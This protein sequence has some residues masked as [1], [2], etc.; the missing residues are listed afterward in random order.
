LEFY[1]GNIS[2]QL[3]NLRRSLEWFMPELTLGLTLPLLLVLG[4]LLPRHTHRVILPGVLGL[5]LVWVAWQ[6]FDQSGYIN[7]TLQHAWFLNLITVDH[8]SVNF[9]LL[10][11]LATA[12]SLIIALVSPPRSGWKTEFWLF[13]G[14]ALIGMNLLCLSSNLLMVYLGMETL[15]LSSY[16]MT[17]YMRK[18]GSAAEAGL[19]YFIFGS[20]ATAAFLYGSSLL[21]G[22]TGTLDFSNP[23]F[24][25][26]LLAQPSLL[27]ATLAFILVWGG[28]A[29]KL[30]A[31]PLHFWSPDVYEGS[32]SAVAGFL[33]TGPKI[34]ALAVVLRFL[35]AFPQGTLALN[36]EYFIGITALLSMIAGNT[37]ALRQ[38][39]LHRLLAWSGIAHT[40]YLL[41]VLIAP[42]PATLASIQWYLLIYTLANLSAF[43]C[44]ALI[45]HYHTEP[46]LRLLQGMGKAYSILGIVL[47][48]AFATLG[49]LPPTSGFPAKIKLFLPLLDAW[50]NSNNPLWLA[51]LIGMFVNAIVGLYYYVRVGKVLY[52]D[53][54]DGV[55]RVKLAWWIWGLLG[56]MGA[57]MVGLW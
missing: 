41:A 9:R 11:L 53:A 8:L 47:I 22:L 40:G 34:A 32:P 2:A 1:Y 42:S 13:L 25:N 39:N 45:R 33:S 15:S 23:E 20:V 43:T 18:E 27:P 14:T 35:P 36:I 52:F 46:D 48:L 5:V 28:F 57:G 6:T 29:F 24:A 38:N 7:G 12:L 10:G 26:R 56:V 16:L 21:Y 50:N 44:L 37:A 54:G 3:D 49:G 19:K 30:S 55:S 17:G 31:F 51:L 4:I